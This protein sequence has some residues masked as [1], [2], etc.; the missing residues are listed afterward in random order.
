MGSDVAAEQA[1]LAGRSVGTSGLAG[2][3]AAALDPDGPTEDFASE[4]QVMTAQ[5]VACST[6]TSSLVVGAGRPG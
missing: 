3:D 4:G 2:T 1:A 5:M 6:P